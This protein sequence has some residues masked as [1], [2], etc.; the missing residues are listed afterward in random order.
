MGKDAHGVG[1][2]QERDLGLADDFLDADGK[3]I[4]DF[5]AAQKLANEWRRDNDGGQLQPNGPLTV[6]DALERYFTYIEQDDRP[7]ADMRLRAHLHT[8]PYTHMTMRPNRE[9]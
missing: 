7:T 8:L 3:R 1:H 6:R 5:K 4:L 2:Y 9:V